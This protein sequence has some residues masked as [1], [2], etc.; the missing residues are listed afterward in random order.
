MSP[1]AC[2]SM[3]LRSGDEGGEHEKEQTSDVRQSN[4][5]GRQRLSKLEEETAPFT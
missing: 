3:S 5:A 2:A 4:G 1:R